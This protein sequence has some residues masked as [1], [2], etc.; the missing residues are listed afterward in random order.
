MD[1]ELNLPDPAPFLIYRF[2]AHFIF[3]VLFGFEA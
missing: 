2:V 3:L 1:Q